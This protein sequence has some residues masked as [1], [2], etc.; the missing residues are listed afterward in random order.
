VICGVYFPVLWALA[1]EPGDRALFDRA[2]R[3]LGGFNHGSK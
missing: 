3:R 2:R 1:F